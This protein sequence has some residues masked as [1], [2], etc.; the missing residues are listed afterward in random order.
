MVQDLQQHICPGL[1]HK[2]RRELFQHHCTGEGAVSVVAS[3]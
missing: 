3:V 1:Q 2:I